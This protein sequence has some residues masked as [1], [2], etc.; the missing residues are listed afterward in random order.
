MALRTIKYTKTISLAPYL[1]LKL[2]YQLKMGIILT[3]AVNVICCL[4]R[5]NIIIYI[6]HRWLSLISI[7]KDRKIKLSISLRHYFKRMMINN[8]RILTNRYS[9]RWSILALTISIIIQL[10]QHGILRNLLNLLGPIIEFLG[11]K[12]IGKYGQELIHL[13]VHS[14]R[15]CSIFPT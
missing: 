14:V 7:H 12:S 9:N 4:Q 1:G 5:I 10:I 6:A 15:I 3:N 11:V 2:N 8:Y 13:N